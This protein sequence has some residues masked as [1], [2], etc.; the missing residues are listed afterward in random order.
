[1]GERA[2]N[3]N[4]HE[5]VFIRAISFRECGINS[6]EKT[7]ILAYI[8]GYQR[9]DEFDIMWL[10]VAALLGGFLCEAVISEWRSR[11]DE[12]QAGRSD[13][14]GHGIDVSPIAPHLQ[15][16]R[17]DHA[18]ALQMVPRPVSHRAGLVAASR[19]LLASLPFFRDAKAE[20]E[21]PPDEE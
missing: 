13:P 11:V 21:H 18:A 2:L 14:P 12:K 10:A 17:E 7:S 9:M 3:N 20:P 6:L 8:R 1:M 15:H 5:H 4:P 16:V 19:R